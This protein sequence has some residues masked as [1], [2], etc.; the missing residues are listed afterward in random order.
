MAKENQSK[1]N[2]GKKDAKD[3][4]DRSATQLPITDGG[5]QNL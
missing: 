4:T 2:D 1:K 5:V 3:A